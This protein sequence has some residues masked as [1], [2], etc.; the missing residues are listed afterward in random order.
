MV[1]EDTDIDEQLIKLS[2]VLPSY[3]ANS[4]I[5]P[6]I[7]GLSDLQK[8]VGQIAEKLDKQEHQLAHTPADKSLSG[9]VHAAHNSVAA[10]A[11]HTS[12]SPSYR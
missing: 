9:S 12:E 10:A 5:T 7:R 2:A 4:H 8:L 1:L 6:V 11:M 3:T